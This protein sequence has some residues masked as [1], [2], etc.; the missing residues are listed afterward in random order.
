MDVVFLSPHYPPDMVHFTRGLAEVGA[1]IRAIGDVPLDQVP[2]TVRRHLAG[3]LQVSSWQDLGPAA[4]EIERWIRGT[5]VD[6]IETLWEPLILLAAE[7]RRRTGCPGLLPEQAILFRD[8]VKM[9]AQVAAAGLRTPRG[10]R[11]HSVAECVAATHEI[12]FPVCI[13]PVA[14]AGSQD[15]YRVGDAAELQHITPRLRHVPEV[16]VE[17]FIDGDEFTFDALWQDGEPIFHSITQYF[18]RPLESRM[19]E[20][21]SPAQITFRHPDAPEFSDAQALARG[22]VRALGLRSGFTHMEWFR[23]SRGEAVFGEI[24]ARSGGGHLVDMMNYS[25]DCDLFRGWAELACYGRFSEPVHRRYHVG[26]VFKR[27]EGQGRIRAIHGA[28]KVLAVCGEN[29][30]REDLLPIGAQRRDWR[31]TVTSDGFVCVRHP[32]FDRVRQMVRVLVSDLRLY[33]GG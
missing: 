5:N 15:T 25:N 7:L 28:E 4:E 33:A 9:K 23:N 6:R 24:G 8:K 26:L 21:I 2:E 27:A 10:I 17:E 3:Y 14:G 18:P 11:A 32:E 22:V 12:G 16:T 13:K 1:R 31:Q 30:I 19:N 29:I 20:W